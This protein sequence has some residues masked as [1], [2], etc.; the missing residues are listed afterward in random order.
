MPSHNISSLMQY[1]LPL[2]YPLIQCTIISDCFERGGLGPLS[3]SSAV[4]LFRSI[5]TVASTFYHDH[6]D[7][8]ADYSEEDKDKYYGYLDCSFSRRK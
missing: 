5:D 6:T 1:S 2:S 7:E 8:C 3:T 4:D